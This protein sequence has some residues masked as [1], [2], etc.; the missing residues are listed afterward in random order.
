M[1]IHYHISS[2]I[3]L[4]VCAFQTR[5][6]VY[7]LGDSVLLSAQNYVTGNIQWQQSADN[8]TWTDL[9]GATGLSF[10]IHPQASAYYRLLIT[11]SLCL[12]PYATISQYVY[13][14]PKPDTAEA[15]SDQLNAGGT[16]VTLSANNPVFGSGVWS[17]LSGAG[18]SFNNAGNPA[19]IFTG[20]P[21]VVYTLR[22][23]ISNACGSTHDDIQVSFSS[24]FTCGNNIT[25]P[26]DGQ[27]YPTLLIGSQCWMK[28]N[29][30]YGQQIN[31][32]THQTD[33]STP[34]KYCYDNV[35]ANCDIYGGM[36]QWNEVMQYT[37]T[38]SAQGLCPAGWHVPSDNEWKTLEMALGMTQQEADMS[39]TWRGVGVG[40]ALKT[41]GSSGF[42]APLGGGLWGAGG[43]FMFVNSMG[44]LWTSNE[45]SSNAWRR[46]L[47]AT[48]DKVGRWDTFPKTYGFNVRCVK[49]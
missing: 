34:E 3:V 19:A 8:T 35:A 30:N 32:S 6:Q 16:S 46:C 39:N 41:G 28:K 43:S 25:D 2:C 27:L 7:C 18:G 44:Y 47:S 22:W 31:S 9:S 14:S 40:T 10:M 23:T 21:A 15:G 1:K 13:L 37:T 42:D 38:E 20:I 12:P 26:R 45:S 29:L 33:N 17:V 36:Y 48:D 11:D 4:L 49:N 5:A 24:T